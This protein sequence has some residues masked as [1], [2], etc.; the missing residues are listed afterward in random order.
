MEQYIVSSRKYRPQR[1]DQVI[2]Q[3]VCI[4]TL[5][6][7]L[8]RGKTA[9][10]YLFSGPRGTGKTTLVRILAKAMNCPNF[11]PETGEPC[12]TCSVCQGIANS[13]SLDVLE[14]DGASNRGI[15][16]IRTLSETIGYSPAAGKYKIFIIDEVHMLTK[17]AFNALLKNLEEPPPTAKFFFATTEPHKIP[18]TIL[19]RCQRF[20]L[21]R[22]SHD[23][24]A[25]KLSLIA[26]ENNLVLEPTVFS[27]L[28][29]YADGGLRDAESLFDQVTSYAIDGTVGLELLEEVLGIAPLQWFE[30]LDRA[31]C[32]GNSTTAFELSDKVLHSSKDIGRFIEDLIFH[33]RT[34]Y[35][36]KI[37]SKKSSTC[38][39]HASLATLSQVV[40]L[41]QEEQLQ[42]IFHHLQE[43]SKNIKQLSSPRFTLEKLLL[44][45]ISIRHD[46][47]LPYIVK[48]LALLEETLSKST[49]A[50]PTQEKPNPPP[51]ESPKTTQPQSRPIPM[52]AQNPEQ[53]KQRQEHL[54][55]FA[56]VELSGTLQKKKR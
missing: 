47:P 32:S 16:D 5:K 14:I 34:A 9:S 49:H 41:L 53:E 12:C 39:P 19:S 10:A 1:F 26:S 7:A 51:Q 2:G 35:L 38:N 22:L 46:I 21:K 17:E 25:K 45:I 42:K 3:E 18:E 40:S 11:D 44:D 50:Q 52:T 24:I 56:A 30:E 55:Q 23:S 20:T 31:I 54:M 37:N 8:K 28:A 13:S 43:A 48:R 6:N 33:F 27:T 15:D 4:R 36:L 29:Q